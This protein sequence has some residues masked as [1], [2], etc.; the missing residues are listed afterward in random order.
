MNR[1]AIEF[2]MTINFDFIVIRC[3]NI[4]LQWNYLLTLEFLQANLHLYYFCN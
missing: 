3:N 4:L 1:C 2:S